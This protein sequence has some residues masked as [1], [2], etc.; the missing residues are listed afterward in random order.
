MPLS[1]FDLDNTLITNDSDYLWG[2]Y[3]VDKNIVNRDEY[4]A[5]NR[6]FFSDYEQ[7]TL[8]IDAY[9]K[10]SLAPLT[11]HD[12][13]TLYRWRSDFMSR[14]IEPLIAPGT[15]DLLNKH[16]RRGDT[17]MI[18][19]ATNLFIT[20]PIAELLGVEH[21]LATQPEFRDGRYTGDYVG[22]ATYQQGKV[23]ALQEWLS[24]ND[25]D[26]AGSSFY[27]DSINDLPLLEQVEN[28]YTVNPDDRLLEVASQRGWPVLDLR[29]PQPSGSGLG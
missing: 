29:Q 14:V 2:Q 9:L 11:Q 20:E 28:P 3:L 7:G 17:L 23:N 21:I 4:E 22:H 18:I 25:M 24:S 8:D 1:L 26:L 15:P 6:Q 16:R 19:S 13:A 12:P 27:S 10:F 5:R